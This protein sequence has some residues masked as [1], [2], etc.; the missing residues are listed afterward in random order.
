MTPKPPSPEVSGVS[1][2]WSD[3]FGA[4]AA[5]ELPIE[6]VHCVLCQCAPCRCPEFGTPAYF[7]LID[8]RHGRAPRPAGGAE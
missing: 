5:G 7:A 3:D 4:Y 8:Q 6:R 2:L 1:T